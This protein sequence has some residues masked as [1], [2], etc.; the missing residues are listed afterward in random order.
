MKSAWPAENR[1]KAALRRVERYKGLAMKV[2]ASLGGEHVS[3]GRDVTSH[4]NAIISLMEA[5]DE[6]RRF[7]EE[8][9][10]AEK[11]ISDVLAKMEDDELAQLLE[12]MYLRHLS[13]RKI[14]EKMYH[15]KNWVYY[16]LN[17]ALKQLEDVLPE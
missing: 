9:A 3:G 11:N 1:M 15:G 13:P 4:E 14:A 16:N 2:T 10:A 12:L 17:T 7:A 5:E 6:A 8:Y